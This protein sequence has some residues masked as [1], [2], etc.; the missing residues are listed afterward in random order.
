M[1]NQVVTVG[2]LVKTPELRKTE[3]G[4][5]ITNITLAVPRSYKN[6]DGV[7]DTDFIDI[8]LWANVAENTCDYCRIGDI[9]G[10]RGRLQV[11]KVKDG[12]SKE[13][14]KLELIGEKVTFLTSMS[15]D[16]EIAKEKETKQEGKEK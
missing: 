9:V 7:Y 8:T 16:K 1:L 13:Y 12:A 5:L 14:N 4:R 15:K 6:I 10:V 3:H 11:E 2:R